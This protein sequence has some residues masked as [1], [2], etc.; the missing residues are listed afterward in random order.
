MS[1]G[2][3][4][5][6]LGLLLLAGFFAGGV[7][8]ARKTNRPLAIGCAVACALAIAAAVLRLV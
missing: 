1:T 5:L 2:S 4:V 3:Y 7:W 8:A 6:V